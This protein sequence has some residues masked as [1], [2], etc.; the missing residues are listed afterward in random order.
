VFEATLAISR[1]RQASVAEARG[2]APIDGDTV[3][4]A[5]ARY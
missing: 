1:K 5:F 2:A 4:D 3:L